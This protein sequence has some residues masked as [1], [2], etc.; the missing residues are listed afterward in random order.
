[1]IHPVAN[2]P[3]KQQIIWHLKVLA[4][5][6]LISVFFSLVLEQKVIHRQSVSMLVLTFVQLELFIWIG[7]LFFYRLKEGTPDFKKKMLLHLLYFYLTVI[8]I[9]G[10]LFIGVFYIYY[11][12]GKIEFDSFYSAIKNLE[13][14]GFFRTT[15]IGFTLGALFFFYTQWAEALKREQKLA[16]EKLIF[17]NETLKSQINPHF[18]FNS[19]NTLSSL[20]G[21]NPDL[22]ELFIQKLSGTYRYILDNMEKELVP[23]S[24][25]I[26]FVNDYFYLQKIR[27]D[28]K[29]EL[30]TELTIKDTALIVPVSLQLLVENALKH[31]SA[32]RRQPL[33]I[34]IHNE[35]LDK[36]VVRNNLQKKTQLNDSSK[37]G[38]KNLGERCRLLLNREIEIQET[39]DEF[40]VKLP[41]KPV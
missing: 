4:G 36:L 11:V 20:V 6:A 21:T 31:N 1:M 18:L 9:A 3:V 32:T 33:E 17:Q 35:G 23:L 15:L 39:T 7:T 22:S 29:I 8:V 34:I 38:L 41:V 24:Q 28:D 13:L 16:H 25:E 37:I 40:V 2:K 14:K 19:L 26:G 27:D 5:A 10:L 12:S 30:R